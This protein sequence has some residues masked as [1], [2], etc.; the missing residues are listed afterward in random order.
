MGGRSVE[1]YSVENQEYGVP[2]HSKQNNRVVHIKCNNQSESQS[3][4]L[5]ERRAGNKKILSHREGWVK[6]GNQTAQ[7]LSVTALTQ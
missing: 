6:L 2:L 5:L 4:L 7:L 1:D 3:L